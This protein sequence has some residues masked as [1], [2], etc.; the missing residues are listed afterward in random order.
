M[1]QELPFAIVLLAAGSLLWFSQ[2]KAEI[3]ASIAKENT[4]FPVERAVF[5]TASNGEQLAN[6]PNKDDAGFNSAITNQQTHQAW[7]GQEEESKKKRGVQQPVVTASFQSVGDQSVNSSFTQDVAQYVHPVSNPESVEFLAEISKQ[8][9]NSPSFGAS[10]K[11]TG[12]LF[13]QTVSANGRYFQMGQG[14]GKS[15][16][17]LRFGDSAD[18][19]TVFQLC[20]GRFVYN[21]QTTGPNS[22]PTFEFVDLMRVRELSGE[23]SQQISPT[24]WIATGGISSLFQHLA[25][26]FNFG[27]MQS[28]G[29]DKILLRGSWDE[30]ALRRIVTTGNDIDLG[31]PV[32]WE[33]VPVQLPHA[34]EIVLQKHDEFGF[35]PRRI[36]FQKFSIH[37]NRIVLQPIVTLKLDAPKSLPEINDQF[38]VIDS[39]NL[40]SVDATDN[41]IER[42]QLFRAIPFRPAGQQNE[43]QK[44]QAPTAKIR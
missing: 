14:S 42:I 15:R 34:V 36:S 43:T 8:L 19:P 32:H 5:S 27:E 37:E 26:A 33:K 2:S 13:E 39:S 23:Q 20:D 7:F 28:N 1:K 11:L 41:Y 30:N 3:D 18:A 40:E 9:A 16:I 35:F 24:G 12:N 38:F 22:I 44:A 17:D 10:L 4:A 25:S 6:T 29:D 21:L 31:T